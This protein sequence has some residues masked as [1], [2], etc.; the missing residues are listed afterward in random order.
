MNGNYCRWRTRALAGLLAGISLAGPAVAQDA[1]PFAQLLR[2]TI[3]APRLEGLDAEVDRAKGLERQAHAW[4]NPTVSVLTENIG[5]STPYTRFDRAETTLQVNQPLEIGGKRSSR[6]LAER[7]GVV[8][9][10]A[11]NREGRIAYAYDLA[12]A[13]AGVEIAERRIERAQDE[14]E[15]NEAIVRLTKALV[16]TGKEA[17][18]RQ[19]QSESELGAARAALEG[20]RAGRISALARLSAL[21]GRDT[22]FSGTSESLLD[23]LDARSATGP[24]DPMLNAAY[25]SAKAEREAADRRVE[26]ERRRINPDVTVQVGVRRLEYEGATSLL[27]GVSLPLPLFDRNR[28]NVDAARA[29]LR[30]AEA[31]SEA[32]RLEAQAEAQAAMAQ[33]DAADTRTVAA[34]DAM[35]TANEAYRLARIAYEA[36]KAPLVELLNARR[37][38][39]MA[40][41][42]LIDVSAARFQARATLA[43][44]QGLTIT[45]EPVQ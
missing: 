36:G 23:R 35:G 10:T 13:Y 17:R 21:S 4:P 25:L 43:R 15:Q 9:A 16:D 38:V 5:G 6:I 2:D 45:G 8:A 37:A 12:L 34:R 40:A 1:P 29:A 30:G 44:L 18:L 19:L 41:T 11:R 28:G 24:V 31:R 20:T 32:A 27:A 22:T 33:V 42:T 3:E 39:G 14:V 26:A 7:A